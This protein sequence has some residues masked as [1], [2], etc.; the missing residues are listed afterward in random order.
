MLPEGTSPHELYM[1][2]LTELLKDVEN[3]EE[4]IR[5]GKDEY[6]KDEYIRRFGKRA[7]D[8]YASRKAELVNDEKCSD[9][10][11]ISRFGKDA[12]DQ[13][14]NMKKDLR[15]QRITKL[16]EIHHELRTHLTK[17]KPINA[18]AFHDKMEALIQEQ[19]SILTNVRIHEVIMAACVS[20][21]P[22][23]LE[24]I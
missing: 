1:E 24:P 19:T 10:E 13:D 18:K 20:P 17:F 11:Y 21:T 8:Q 7:H 5:V 4:S 2:K 16:K 9:D 14:M 23:P 22:A 12:Y 15:K 6:S 3:A